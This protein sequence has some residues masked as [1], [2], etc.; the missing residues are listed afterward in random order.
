MI[1]TELTEQ[2][3][4]TLYQFLDDIALGDKDFISYT[5]NQNTARAI[6][7]KLQQHPQY[8]E[9]HDGAYFEKSVKD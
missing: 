1:I 5:D 3:L 4:T 8:M 9:D 6:M 2:D 7:R